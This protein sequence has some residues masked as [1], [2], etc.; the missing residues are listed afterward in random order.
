MYSYNKTVKKK[1]KNI[2]FSQLTVHIHVALGYHWSI[3]FLLLFLIY[4][5]S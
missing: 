1:K 5:W 3:Y 2:R 4:F